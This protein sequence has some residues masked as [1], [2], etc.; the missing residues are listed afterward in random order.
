MLAAFTIAFLV[1]LGD[2]NLLLFSSVKPYYLVDNPTYVFVDNDHLVPN[3]IRPTCSP[4]NIP[5]QENVK[6][7]CQLSG[8]SSQGT[9]RK[10]VVKVKID[11]EWYP[12]RVPLHAD[13]SLNFTCL[14]SSAYR[15]LI[16]VWNRFGGI[17]LDE[18]PNGPIQLSNCPVTNCVISH[19]RRQLN[20]SDYVLFHMRSRI[21]AF[22][23]VRFSRQ[24]WVYVVYE[25][26][27][28]C[29]MCTRLEGYFNLSATFR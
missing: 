27:Q 26:Q 11:N 16:L 23:W 19:D 25:S 4:Y 20:E 22:P 29:P 9:N 24:K 3:V 12:E 8:G 5:R 14:S 17:P 13:R 21:D 28:N 1:V 6:V 2:F 18:I 10:R 15:P 7:T